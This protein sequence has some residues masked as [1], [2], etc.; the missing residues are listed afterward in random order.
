MLVEYMTH[1]AFKSG[2]ILVFL[3]LSK[4]NDALIYNLRFALSL[5]TVCELQIGKHF[6]FFELILDLA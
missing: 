3:K 1:M 5:K 6:C 2:Y 4:T